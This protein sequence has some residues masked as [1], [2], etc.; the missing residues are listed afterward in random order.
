MPVR[1][2]LAS[3]APLRGPRSGLTSDRRCRGAASGERCPQISGLETRGAHA[4]RAAHSNLP[5]LGVVRFLPGESYRS[6]FLRS[7]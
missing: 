4:S 5:T 2:R 3:D 1:R 6:K 7:A